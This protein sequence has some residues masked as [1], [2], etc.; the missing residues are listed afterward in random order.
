MKRIRTGNQLFREI[1]GEFL[2]GCSNC[3]DVSVTGGSND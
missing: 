2:D 3:C 1:G